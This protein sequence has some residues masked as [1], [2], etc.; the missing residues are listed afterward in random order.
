MNLRKHL[1][2]RN[3]DLS[4]HSAWL[5][6]EE[7]VATFPLWNLSG[8]MVG[9]QQ[10]RPGAE[11]QQ[12]NPK[13]AR[14]F[15]KLKDNKVGV[16][17]LESWNFTNTLFLTEGV[18]DAARLTKNSVSALAVLTYRVG[19]TCDNWLWT[20]SKG[21][22]VVS[23]CEGDKAGRK[24]SRYGHESLYLPNGEDVD[25]MSENQFEELLREVEEYNAKMAKRT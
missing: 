9:Y 17:G 19:K 25:S 7:G 8:Q 13:D 22:P 12:N 2:C 5:D 23:V 10:Y 15:N 21:R 24:L 16:W 20:V 18:F 4:L 3:Y 14:Y 11:K 6:E 1:E